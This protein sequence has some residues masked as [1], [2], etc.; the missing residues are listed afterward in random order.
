MTSRTKDSTFADKSRYVHG[1]TTERTTDR[2][3]Y[4]ER[5][6]IRPDSSDS[7]YVL[8]DVYEARPDL[9]AAV[10][11]DDSRLWWVICQVN[12]ILDVQEEF[13]TGVVLS[14][15]NKERL[16]REILRSGSTGGINSKR[17]ARK[18]IEQII[19]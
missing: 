16:E 8:E 19:V 15:P 14:I 18:R 4:W 12:N 5:R 9:V 1:G 11:Y 7:T 3:E 2:L 10:F 6:I 13:V 17:I